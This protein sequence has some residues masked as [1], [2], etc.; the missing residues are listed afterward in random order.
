MIRKREG[1]VKQ[2]KKVGGERWNDEKGERERW[3][4]KK[5]RRWDETMTEGKKQRTKKLERRRK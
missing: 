3:Y 4:N 2:C 5:K 1:E